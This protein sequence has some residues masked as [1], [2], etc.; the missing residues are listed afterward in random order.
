M[1]EFCTVSCFTFVSGTGE[2]GM[3][4]HPLLFVPFLFVHLSTRPSTTSYNSPTFVNEETHLISFS[5]ES[6]L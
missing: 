5:G 3:E 2:V 6:L 4:D 1:K